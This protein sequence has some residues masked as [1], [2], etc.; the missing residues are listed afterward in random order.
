MLL[1]LDS[2]S[3]ISIQEAGNKV[4]AVAESMDRHAKYI[5]G[6]FPSITVAQQAVDFIGDV[7]GKSLIDLKEL[8]K[9]V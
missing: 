3:S 8:P 7:L 1:N 6:T 2:V 9:E 4:H 5:L